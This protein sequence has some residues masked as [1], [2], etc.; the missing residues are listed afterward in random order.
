MGLVW[1]ATPG[2]TN[3][4]DSVFWA[5]FDLPQF[6]ACR[7]G[8]AK[9][10]TSLPE[11]HG[12]VLFSV[13]VPRPDSSFYAA[14][15]GVPLG[16]TGALSSLG[17]LDEFHEIYHDPDLKAV[18]SIADLKCRL[19][20]AGIRFDSRLF[21]T[22]VYDGAE[23]AHRFALLHPTDVRAVA[24]VC[25]NVFTIPIE[26]LEDGP[27]PW[28]LGLAGFESLGHGVFDWETYLD[29]PYYVI[30]SSHE[31]LWYNEMTPEEQGIEMDDL[32][33]FVSCFGAIPP[34]RAAS[35]VEELLAAGVDCRLTWSEGGHGWIDPVRLRVLEFFAAFELD[36]SP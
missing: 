4:S 6:L 14:R 24:P 28:P 26:S 20:G 27:L 31:D 13:A 30:A 17:A 21:L 1:H 22:G 29:I 15:P 36:A 18:E 8:W 11:T 12:L 35:F 10:P 3:P 19:T 33:R 16:Y 34:E 7:P 2:G 9:P 32:D 23:W 25:G 5:K